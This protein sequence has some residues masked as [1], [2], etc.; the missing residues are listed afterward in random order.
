MKPHLLAVAF[1]QFSNPNNSIHYEIQFVKPFK[2]RRLAFSRVVL[3]WCKQI[4][5]R[6]IIMKTKA[7]VEKKKFTL[8]LNKKTG[9]FDKDSKWK[10]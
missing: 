3:F 7:D 5:V 6:K 4:V 9:S 10:M 8:N 2:W 1:N